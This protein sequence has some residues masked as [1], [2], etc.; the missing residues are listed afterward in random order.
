MAVGWIW[1]EVFRPPSV[2][3]GPTGPYERLPTRPMIRYS[4]PFLAQDLAR[5]LDGLDY[6]G[7]LVDAA[8]EDLECDPGS[9]V[10]V[11]T[12]WIRAVETYR[13]YPSPE[14]AAAILDGSIVLD[15]GAL[16]QTVGGRE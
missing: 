6:A 5:R 11:W 12:W 4:P 8:R 13:R 15:T 10:D 14:A 3:S 9:A 7:K 16:G 2:P 1:K